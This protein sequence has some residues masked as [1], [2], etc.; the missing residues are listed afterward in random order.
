[1]AGNY[2]DTLVLTALLEI[3]LI[4]FGGYVLV[5]IVNALACLLD[6][7]DPDI[8]FIHFREK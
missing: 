7:G 2:G 1:M 8:P 5:L 3:V 4:L 6:K